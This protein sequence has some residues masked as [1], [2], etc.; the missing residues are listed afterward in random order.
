MSQKTTNRR[1][2]ISSIIRFKWDQLR[3]YAG[4]PYHKMLLFFI[5]TLLFIPLKTH[6]A[7]VIIDE[8]LP[9]ISL[10]HELLL[11]EEQDNQQRTIDEIIN[12]D[13]TLSFFSPKK[14][15]PSFVGKSYPIWGKITLLNSSNKPLD[16]RLVLAQTSLHHLSFFSPEAET[17]RYVEKRSD[18]SK[19]LRDV[20]QRH[21]HFV[22]NITL[23][24]QQVMTYYVRIQSPNIKLYLYLYE[25][26]YFADQTLLG[27]IIHGTL[28]GFVLAVIAYQLALFFMAR[29][30][31]YWSLLLFAMTGLLHQFWKLGYHNMLLEEYSGIFSLSWGVIQS[32]TSSSVVYFSRVFLTTKTHFPRLDT[33][34]KFFQYAALATAVLSLIDY[35]SA[36]RVL[37]V[38]VPLGVLVIFWVAIRAVMLGMDHSRHYLAGWIPILVTGFY[39]AMVGSGIMS[40]QSWDH[41]M[42][43]LGVTLALFLFAFAVANR[44]GHERMEH[45][46]LREERS[47][48]TGILEASPVAVLVVNPVNDL[49]TLAN[50]RASDLLHW[51]QEP[52]TDAPIAQFFENSDDQEALFDMARQ[53]QLIQDH[54][55]ILQ[56]SQTSLFHG[57]VSVVPTTLGK[58]AHFIVWIYDI[59]Q[60]KKAEEQLL[61]AKREADRANRAKSDFLAMISHEVRTPMNGILG[62]VQLLLRSTLNL[63]QRHQMEILYSSSQNLLTLLNDLLDLS[64]IEAGKLK[65]NTAPFSPSHMVDRV[66][67]LEMSRADRKGLKLSVHI[68]PDIPDWL[69]GDEDRLRQVLLNLVSNAIKFTEQGEVKILLSYEAKD[70]ARGQFIAKVQDT[71]IGIPESFQKHL[72]DSFAQH[73]MSS[74]RTREG[75]GLGLSICLKLMAAMNG[76]IFFESTEGKGS[77]FWFT[78]PLSLTQAPTEIQQTQKHTPIPQ[79]LR[80]L[81]AEDMYAN[82]QVILGMLEAGKHQVT[83]TSNGKEA[84]ETLQEEDFDLILMD[85]R[86]PVMDGIST[87][88]A[89][90]VL[91]DQHKAAIPIVAMTANLMEDVITKCLDAGMSHVLG[92]PIDLQ[93]LD[94]ILLAASTQQGASPITQASHITATDNPVDFQ[95]FESITQR[96][97]G[98]ESQ[99]II[100]LCQQA[101]DSSFS[102]FKQSL[103]EQHWPSAKDEI[104]KIKGVAGL[105]G[106]SIVLMAAETL[107]T[108]LHTHERP[109]I[110]TDEF[111]EMMKNL[112]V[113]MEITQSTL[114]DMRKKSSERVSSV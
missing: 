92:K 62:M 33:A 54:D 67:S 57:L 36:M 25:P 41:L 38:I 82:Q 81:V 113:A 80:I 46:A 65:L 91:K 60:R 70:L 111:T 16:R 56:T 79:P 72:F 114:T 40:V 37:Q 74:Q 96:A 88:Q 53:G 42:V 2:K 10:G 21:R 63:Q 55:L 106:F 112:Q 44:I 99:D 110:D 93:L 108:Y 68:D 77:L 107:N 59:S 66:I 13:N 11:F 89:I 29:D 84:L 98:T 103:T 39:S 4:R 18:A 30:P 34:L 49:I 24:P 45:N 105:Y 76:Q 6:A 104:H 86:M 58:Q 47:R 48:L 50:R 95:L 12:Q 78:L 9:R 97:A 101:L 94:D 15:I 5:L 87:T 8:N 102:I 85:L 20:D 1:L 43:P 69:L 64:R 23:P 32:L 90:R 73:D 17:G 28:F 61:I 75:A 3:T 35:I 83:L 22:Y 19:L 26:D 100:Q 27:T 52:L 109:R 51:Q 14:K 71:G 7:T 31:S